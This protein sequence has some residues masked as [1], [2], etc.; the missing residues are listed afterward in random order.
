VSQDSPR[1]GPGN[2]FTE[3]LISSAL[4][5]MMGVVVFCLGLVHFHTCKS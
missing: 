2:S 5:S 4:K 3:S 1:K